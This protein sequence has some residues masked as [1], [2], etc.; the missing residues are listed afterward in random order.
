ML[1]YPYALGLVQFQ[2]WIICMHQSMAAHDTIESV[3]ASVCQV[4]MHQ[5]LLE[6]VTTAFACICVMVG[7]QDLAQS[8][9]QNSRCTTHAFHSCNCTLQGHTI[10][11][12]LLISKSYSANT[13]LYRVADCE[14]YQPQAQSSDMLLCFHLSVVIGQLPC[15]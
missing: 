11:H 5:S 6:A 14:K 4:T 15:S 2:C 3:G 9:Y 1:T 8:S 13:T 7:R 12:A 10:L